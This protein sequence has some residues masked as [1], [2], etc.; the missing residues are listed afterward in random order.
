MKNNS[1]I[2]RPYGSYR[3]SLRYELSSY[4][5]QRGLSNFFLENLFFS[6]ASSPSFAARLTPLIAEFCQLSSLKKLSLYDMGAGLGLLSKFI[7]S[8]MHTH[9]PDLNNCL[10]YIVSDLSKETIHQLKTLDVFSGFSNLSFSVLDCTSPI[11]S[12]EKLPSI[13]LMIYLLD[14][15][16]SRH[17]EVDKNQ[18][19]ELQI[20]TSISSD[21]AIID[22]ESCPPSILDAADIK[23]LLLSPPSPKKL[24]H[25]SRL[26]DCLQETYRRVPLSETNLTSFE[27]EHLREFVDYLK[28]SHLTRFNYSQDIYL[29]LNRLF[30]A[31]D[32]PLMTLLYDFG[33]T[34]VV[35]N[36]SIPHLTGCYGTC[37]FY[38]IF[39]PYIRFLCH[40][41]KVDFTVTDYKQGNSQL[42]LLSRGVKTPS[43]YSLFL[44]ETKKEGN[45]SVAAVVKEIPMLP[46]EGF[47]S[48]LISLTATLPPLERQTYYLLIIQSKEAYIRGYISE[49]IEYAK[50]AID[51]YG[52]ISIAAYLSLACCYYKQ[53]NYDSS[54]KILTHAIKLAP[55]CYGLYYQLSLIYGHL[56]YSA[57]FI[58]TCLN[59]YRYIDH[60]DTLIW[61]HYNTLALM[62]IQS[63]SSSSAL[64]LIEWLLDTSKDYPELIPLKTV[65]KATVIKEKFCQ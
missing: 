40:Q 23:R 65:K 63:E 6:Y 13:V 16:P 3:A 25:L 45:L 8:H 47:I 22:T 57:L 5:W 58:E 4:S 60:Q 18:I 9:Y 50:A 44:E 42:A 17:I 29:T 14:S 31:H 26:S 15:L 52:D 38:T 64:L 56:G 30:S 49:S 41:N 61:D 35:S 34:S 1:L 43:L 62:Y 39:F 20:Q 59:Y 33:D 7:L 10:D 54:I 32:G 53:E 55:F 46:K 12:P 27:K 19:Y 37:F 2:V 24:T 28:P 48:K 36:P 11:Y 21:A 51:L